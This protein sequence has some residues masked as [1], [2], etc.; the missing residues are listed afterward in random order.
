M[1][2][3]TDPTRGDTF[4]IEDTLWTYNGRS[5]D[6][7]IV[8]S[9]NDTSYSGG[10]YSLPLGGLPGQVLQLNTEGSPYWGEGGDPDLTA[11]LTR[12]SELE[13]QVATLQG[14]DN[15]LL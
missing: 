7:T 10:S 14:S 9:N 1:A 4:F 2:F 11:L 13:T 3:P 8:G 6:R 5:W 12:V 15:L